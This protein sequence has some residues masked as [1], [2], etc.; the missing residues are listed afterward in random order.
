MGWE[1]CC[2]AK[3]RSTGEKRGPGN[4]VQV[5]YT[6]LGK[7]TLAVY[8]GSVSHTGYTPDTEMS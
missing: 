6:E 8:A 7:P 4:L 1:A 2:I 5:S 3:G